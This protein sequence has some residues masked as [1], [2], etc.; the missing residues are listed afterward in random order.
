VEEAPV[1]DAM[2]NPSWSDFE[3]ARQRFFERLAG[4]A[5]LSQLEA[6]WRLPVL[7]PDA[8]R[9]PRH[10]EPTGPSSGDGQIT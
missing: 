6:V 5:A 2:D 10:R 8:D 1:P 9:D 7:S 3:A 4:D